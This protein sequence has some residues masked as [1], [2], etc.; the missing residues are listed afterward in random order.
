MAGVIDDT[1]R[2]PEGWADGSWRIT[3]HSEVPGWLIIP[4]QVDDPDEWVV[5]RT[6]EIRDAWAEEWNEQWREVVPALL[7]AG[8]DA[9]P[10]GAALAFQIWPVPAPLLAQ[11]SVFFG[12]RPGDLPAEL[13]DGDRYVTDG[14]GD[15]VALVRTL[16]DAV[17][18]S[19]LVG[20][21]LTFIS[22]RTMVVV[23]FEPT[24]VELFGMLVGQFHA[25]V[26]TLEFLD[27]EGRPVRGIVPDELPTAQADDDWTE[28]VIVS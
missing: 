13:A 2:M 11:V 28:S 19:T 20:L 3:G 27:P 22:D 7:R 1:D 25:F 5:G 16:D 15:G 26:H 23:R 18:G 6:D 4:G 12:E 14:L 24:V 8:L 17:S 21:D 10:D 9:R